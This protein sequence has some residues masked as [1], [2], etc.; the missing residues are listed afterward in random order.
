VP[1]IAV[2]GATG[3]VGTMVVRALAAIQPRPTLR[4]LLRNPG[5]RQLAPALQSQP[6]VEGTLED[7]GALQKLVDN[8]DVVVH[9]A[10][11]IAGNRAEEFEQTNI[12]G[13]RRLIEAIESKTPHTHLIQISSLAARVPDLSGYAASKRAAEE[14]IRTRISH[15]TILRPP[16][17]YGPN[18][19]ALEGFWRWLARGWLIRLGPSAARFSL[20]HVQDLAETVVR[21]IDHGPTT[22]TMEVAG[23]QP[24]GGWHWN[25]LADV[26]G[27]R[28]GGPVRIL[29]VPAAALKLLAL[30]SCAAGMLLGR[31][32][33]LNPGKAREL[34]HIDWVCDNQALADRLGWQ[35]STKLEAALATLPGWN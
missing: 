9:I 22:K 31:A 33:I 13:T 6:I 16:A 3:F 10:A 20:L 18:D 2:T 4:L 23:P 15:Y 26:A 14:L 1:V 7:S 29:P 5:R 8:A 12:L 11:A 27:S 28:R 19:P 32:Q 35:P 24:T 17:V 25:A 34:R 30:G 21:L